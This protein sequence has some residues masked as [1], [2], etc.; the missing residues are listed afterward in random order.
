MRHGSLFRMNAGSLSRFP[1][2]CGSSFS[3]PKKHVWGIFDMVGTN[4]SPLVQQKHMQLRQCLDTHRTHR[5][6]LPTKFHSESRH[7]CRDAAVFSVSR[8]VADI[9]Q[10]HERTAPGDLASGDSNNR[11]ETQA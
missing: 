8:R 6:R 9:S 4:I 5:S 11:L 7:L 1:N 10:I 3:L 2:N